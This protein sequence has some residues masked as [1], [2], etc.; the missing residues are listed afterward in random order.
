[1]LQHGFNREIW[2][3]PN[4]KLFFLF[5]FKL[6]DQ[7]KSGAPGTP[8]LW[9]HMIHSLTIVAHDTF[10]DQSGAIKQRSDATMKEISTPIRIQNR[11]D[12]VRT[13]RRSEFGTTEVS[14]YGLQIR[15]ITACWKD[16]FK[17]FPMGRRSATVF[18][19]AWCRDKKKSTVCKFPSRVFSS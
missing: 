16:N 18:I 12:S 6:G 14:S 10:L 19:C 3:L 7:P 1:M 9:L 4:R 8:I 17:Y 13:N 2:V 11:F 5:F 15:Q